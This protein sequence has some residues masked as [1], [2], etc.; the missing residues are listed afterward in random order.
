MM[1]RNEVE[2]RQLNQG[3]H[4]I[5]GL[6]HGWKI[7]PKKERRIAWPG[8]RALPYGDKLQFDVV[9][10]FSTDQREVGDHRCIQQRR[11][12]D[13]WENEYR[14]ACRTVGDAFT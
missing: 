13:L 9:E 11:G 3:P 6:H 1:N 8:M 5:A 7:L 2:V 10:R 12:N 4:R 14:C